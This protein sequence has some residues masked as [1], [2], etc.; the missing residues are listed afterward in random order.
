MLRRQLD[1]PD[2]TAGVRARVLEAL[3]A[4]AAAGFEL[5]D[6][7]FAELDL[8]D[9]A[10]GPILLK[11][12][13]DVHREL[14]EREGDDYGPGTR[15]AARARLEDHRRR[16][17]RR[18]G[19]PA[20]RIAAGFARVFEDVAVLA[21]PTVAYPAPVE[22]PPVGTPEG[23]VEGRYTGRV[24]PRR[25]PG[26]VRALR[27]RRGRA[28]PPGCSSRQRSARTSCCCPWPAIYE[29]IA[30]MRIEDCNWMQVEEYLD[31]DD[32]IVSRSAR[33]SST[34][35]SRSASTGSSPSAWRSRQPSRS[36]CW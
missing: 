36:G 6:V 21:G 7:D 12:A 35:T 4:L 11:E 8:V 30:C 17:P 5:V 16:V 3:E 29:G 25:H 9:A 33:S 34:A 24:Q 15:A 20:R 27:D 28:C 2:L 13:W 19:R 32:R 10:L 14:F 26:R 23:D 31:R 22:D 18:A 1:D